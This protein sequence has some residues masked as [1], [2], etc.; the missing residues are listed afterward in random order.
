M[1]K[2]IR[3]GSPRW[4]ISNVKSSKVMEIR[5]QGKDKVTLKDQILHV[6]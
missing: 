3:T 6:T 2:D 5:S 4:F 1:L